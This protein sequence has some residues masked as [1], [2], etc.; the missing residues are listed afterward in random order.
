MSMSV[1]RHY[2]HH[3]HSGRVHVNTLIEDERWQHHVHSEQDFEGWSRLM[4]DGVLINLPEQQ[5]PCD[6]EPG[7]VLEHDG[8]IWN[9][10][11]FFA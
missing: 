7:Q 1:M 8:R 5:C 2:F 11:Q 10:P 6:L 4:S 9:H 3:D